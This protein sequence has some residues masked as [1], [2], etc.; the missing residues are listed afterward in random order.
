MNP[1][2]QKVTPCIYCD[3]PIPTERE[4]ISVNE[5]VAT[6]KQRTCPATCPGCGTPLE[7]VE[8]VRG[9]WKIVLTE[10]PF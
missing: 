9:R 3:T 8:D 10:N 6:F 2:Y 4:V 5:G 1:A 7:M